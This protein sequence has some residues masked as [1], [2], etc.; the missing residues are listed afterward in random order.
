MNSIY[1]YLFINRLRKKLAIYKRVWLVT[2]DVTMMLYVLAAISYVVV[3]II[4][5]GNIVSKMRSIVPEGVSFKRS[6]LLYVVPMLPIFY[7][8]RAFGQPG[9]LYSS[10]FF[11]LTM[12]P[13]DKS[14]I[15]LALAIE[16]WAKA[17]LRFAM[18]GVLYA[19]LMGQAL[20]SVIPYFFFIFVLQFLMT[21]VEWRFF[22]A[23]LWKKLIGIVL[24][25]GGGA[26]AIWWQRPL[27]VAL[28]VLF[29][30]VLLAYW[31]ARRLMIHMDWEKV[32]SAADFKIWQLPFLAQVTKTP[33]KKDKKRTLWQQFPFWKRPFTLTGKAMYHRIWLLYLQKNSKHILQLLGALML[34]I[35]LLGFFRTWLFYL[36]LAI[37]IHI[38]TSMLAA[39]FRDQ[40][41]T[42]IVQLLPWQLESYRDTFRKWS[43]LLSVPLLIPTVSYVVTNLSGWHLLLLF[44]ALS[45]F[46]VT[47]EIRLERVMQQF[48]TSNVIGNW[49]EAL[50]TLC[51]FILFASYRYPALLWL[52]LIF[53]VIM[54]LSRHKQMGWVRSHS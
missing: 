46:L 15:W 10:S 5:D 7:L 51:L 14:D 31:C 41:T 32:T 30:L 33:I 18:L 4:L 26:I 44:V 49:R 11:T 25:I 16:R 35:S 50:S 37:A 48:D 1:R 8:L 27:V 19:V 45:L 34:M 54:L 24:A 20:S 6:N 53:L 40:F 52:I 43:W 47:M 3:A 21:W 22:Q 9:V 38:Y 39:L 42:G 2:F 13:Y 17:F 29:M 28:L 12:L 36:A 23:P